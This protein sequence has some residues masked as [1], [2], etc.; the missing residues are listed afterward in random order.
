LAEESSV[1]RKEKFKELLEGR[2]KK[3]EMALERLRIIVIKGETTPST[4]KRVTVDK[5]E[6]VHENIYCCFYMQR[7][8]WRRKEFKSYWKENQIKR[9]IGKIQCYCG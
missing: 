9:G 8:Y 3:L 2:T 6:D 7:G 4:I 1:V 5:A